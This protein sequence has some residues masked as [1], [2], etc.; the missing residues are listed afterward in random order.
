[1]SQPISMS[2]HSDLMPSVEQR[3]KLRRWRNIKDKMNAYG[4]MTAGIAVVGSLV[5]IFV[6]LFSLIP[7]EVVFLFIAVFIQNS[8][9]NHK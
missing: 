7:E 5:L 9:Q 1:M 3:A 8:T 6:Y 2:E 4:I